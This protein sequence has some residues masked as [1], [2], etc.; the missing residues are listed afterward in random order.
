MNICTKFVM[1]PKQKFKKE[2]KNLTKVFVLIFHSCPLKVAQGDAVY[3][4]RALKVFWKRMKQKRPLKV[5][6]NCWYGVRFFLYFQLS[7]TDWVS[8][9]IR[10]LE[11]NDNININI[12][13]WNFCN[14]ILSYLMD[15]F[16]FLMDYTSHKTLTA[17]CLIFFYC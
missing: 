8:A 14:F 9:V 15:R 7:A 6:S 3:I 16:A 13:I 2:K 1:F 4:L 11:S 12:N 10:I 5:L 17:A